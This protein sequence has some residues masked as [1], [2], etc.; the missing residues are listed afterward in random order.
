[1]NKGIVYIVFLNQSGQLKSFSEDHFFK[2]L[3]FSI[4]SARE[5]NPNLPITVISDSDIDF[6]ADQNILVEKKADLRRKMSL[7]ELSPYDYTMYI[8][9]DTKIVGCLQESFGLLDRFDMAMVADSTRRI[10]AH[11]DIWSKY[12]SIPN[13]FSEFC[14]GL[15]FYKKSDAFYELVSNWKR[16]YEEWKTVSKVH[17]DQ[18]SFR[19]S[20]WETKN[21]NI[22][23]LPIEYCIRTQDKLDSLHK[24]FP[25]SPIVYH[26]HS[27]YDSNLKRVPHKI[28]L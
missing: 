24:R 8:D 21:L 17:S 18:Q 10:K 13:S 12:A 23:T 19:V 22:H 7:I 9:T 14:S 1:M 3:S 27:M 15:I 20:L 26:W 2:E 4:K 25:K 28:H 5:S 11:A 16:N 6:G